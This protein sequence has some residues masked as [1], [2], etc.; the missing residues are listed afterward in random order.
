MR[1]NTGQPGTRDREVGAARAL[2]WRVVMRTYNMEMDPAS[3]AVT[4]VGKDGRRYSNRDLVAAE[5][6]AAQGD[7][8]AEALLRNLDHG[9]DDDGQRLTVEEVRARAEQIIHDC[10]ACQAAR[11]RGEPVWTAADLPNLGNSHARRRARERYRRAR[12]F[13]AG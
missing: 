7:A 4:L 2:Q 12:R 3:G 6:A 11:A 1:P 9:L 10:P 13:F 5:Q 8:A